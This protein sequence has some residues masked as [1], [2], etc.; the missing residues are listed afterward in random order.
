[1]T[2]TVEKNCAACGKL[3]K[4]RLADHKRGWGRFCDKACS[5][6]YKCGMRPRDVNKQHAK[7]SAW[8]AKAWADRVELGEEA[9]AKAS[10]VKEQLGAKVK[11]KPIYHS[12]ASCRQCGKRINGPGLC[13]D[14]EAHEDGLAA[15]EA[16]WDSHK[17][18]GSAA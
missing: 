2:I 9:F 10:A 14:C 11:V 16:G 18:Y 3:I 17:S 5:A 8:A 1:M 6:G 13:L 12:P 7:K 4:V 15:D